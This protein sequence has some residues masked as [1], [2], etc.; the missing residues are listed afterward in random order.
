MIDSMAVIMIQVLDEIRHSSRP[1]ARKSTD[2]RIEC[3]AV[4]TL[5]PT[6]TLLQRNACSRRTAAA[7]IAARPKA[8][9]L[10]HLSPYRRDCTSQ[11]KIVDRTDSRKFMT[12]PLLGRRFAA[13]ALFP[14]LLGRIPGHTT[15]CND[16]RFCACSKRKKKN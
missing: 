9:S 16:Y 12:Q 13:A 14:R 2:I 15:T 5:R 11:V 7:A 1:R 8:L 10:N 4:Y 3:S 6:V